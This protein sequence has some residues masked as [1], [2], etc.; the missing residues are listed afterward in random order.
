MNIANLSIVPYRVWRNVNGSTASV[1]G[2]VPYRTSAEAEGW[3]VEDAGFT[4]YDAKRNTYGIGR[5][6]FKTKEEGEAWLQAV[7]VKDSLPDNWRD[8]I[9][10]EERNASNRWSMYGN[11][12]ITKIGRKWDST[13][14]GAPLFKTKSE[15]YEFLSTFVC[16]VIPQNC[17]KRAAQ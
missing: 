3:K 8:Y 2:A 16:D 6:P 11:G 14:P 13:A 10:T 9:T 1:C 12:C 15:A 4:V 5:P 7:S 17:A